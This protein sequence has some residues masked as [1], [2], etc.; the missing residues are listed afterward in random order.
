MSDN[1][2]QAIGAGTSSFA[3]ALAPGIQ[4]QAYLRERR[5]E[6]AKDREV[7]AKEREEDLAER[8]RTRQLGEVARQEDRATAEKQFSML[9]A[10]RQTEQA[11]A[12][13]ARL[14]S[15]QRLRDEMSTRSLMADR[16]LNMTREEIEA[17][18]AE[19][20]LLRRE[21]ESERKEAAIARDVAQT[22]RRQELEDAKKAAAADKVH[23][24]TMAYLKFN[25]ERGLAKQAADAESDKLA[26]GS[27]LQDL[28]KEKE[29]E[30]Q[31]R[32]A[33]G[34]EEGAAMLERT[35]KTGEQAITDMVRLGQALDR[36]TAGRHIGD[37]FMD[38]P[39]TIG[40][41]FQK[42]EQQ[43][44]EINR[45]VG[46]GQLKPEE[47]DEQRLKLMMEP[48][49][50]AP[51]RARSMLKKAQELRQTLKTP[52]EAPKA[53]EGMKTK[54]PKQ[55]DI[56]AAAADSTAKE[57][58]DSGVSP[59]VVQATLDKAGGDPGKARRYLFLVQLARLKRRPHY[60]TGGITGLDARRQLTELGLTW[61]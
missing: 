8:E 20:S 22:T 40:P 32:I 57:L 44:A 36:A 28:G 61:K 54:V 23:A 4:Q 24:Y 3:Q 21:R 50:T 47:A 25:M 46:L 16:Q 59:S 58:L 15:E 34:T 2:L 60:D 11:Q 42:R 39:D 52:T 18:K 35:G 45:R 41:E 5:T 7:R 53:V 1:V 19:R 6:V 49:Q 29:L 48:F 55:K 30:D 13:I 43:I 37:L 56:D 26:L 33:L 10:D 51:S 14:E 31:F 17:G 38:D 12:E 9:R 27:Y